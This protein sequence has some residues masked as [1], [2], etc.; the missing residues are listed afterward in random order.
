MKPDLTKDRLRELL[1]Y[2][3]D[4]GRWTWLVARRG[5]AKKRTQAGTISVHGR[6]KIMVDGKI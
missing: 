6:R 3:P 2:D 5:K 4:T 1:H